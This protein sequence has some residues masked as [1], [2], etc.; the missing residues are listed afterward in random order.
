MCGRTSLFIEL[1][2]LESR[3]G[4]T[5][6]ADGGY[7]PRYNIAPGDRLEVVT[8]DTPE[9][10]DRFHWGFIPSWEEDPTTGIINAR[11]E[12]AH[13]KAVFSEAWESRPCVVLSSGF[14]EWQSYN[15]G[16][17]QPYRI[18]RENDSA[19]AM[20][21]LWEEC[22]RNGTRQNCVTIL[23]T[24][25]NEVVEPIHKRMPV[26]LPQEAEEKW[27][28]GDPVERHDLC[29]PYPADDLDAYPIST[30]VNDPSTDD[31][32]VL[33]PAEGEQAGL[34]DFGSA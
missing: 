10:I 11:A 26:V 20:A 4:A 25:P 24:E 19:F 16:P 3:F 33:E 1:D 29:R 5:V 2:D 17:K 31:P 30:R 23:T 34:D 8:N 21:G 9:E 18:Y 28:S 7:T 12:S 14:Y 22:E 6:V 32:Q 27:L 15:G 13:E